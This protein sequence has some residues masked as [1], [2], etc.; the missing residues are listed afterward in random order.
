[1][2]TPRLR[3][4]IAGMFISMTVFLSGSLYAAPLEGGFTFAAGGDVTPEERAAMFREARFRVIV[5]ACKY[6]GVPYRYGGTSKNSLDCSGFVYLSF[7]D[8]LGVIVPR[9]AEGLYRWAEKID[10]EEAQPGDLLFF[11]TTSRRNISHVGIYLGD[12]RFIHSASG[13]RRTGVIYSSLDESY[14]ART[15][16]GAGRALPPSD[17]EGATDTEAA[18]DTEIEDT[19]ENREAL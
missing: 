19:Q 15:Y 18:T 6:E 5:D 2:Q 16:A 13:G 7:R 4:I 10:I 9:N 8:A 1:M 12:R 17:T 11:R 3:K 14:W